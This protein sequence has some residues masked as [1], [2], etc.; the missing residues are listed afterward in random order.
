MQRKYV[1][2]KNDIYCKLFIQV[3]KCMKR[4]DREGI[5]T[6]IAGV[7]VYGGDYVTI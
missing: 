3:N 1:V 5:V 7:C 2:P 4:S 6:N